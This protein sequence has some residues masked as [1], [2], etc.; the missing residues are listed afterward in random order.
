MC[1]TVKRV[2][3]R[4]EALNFIV[5]EINPFVPVRH[6]KRVHTS[7]VPR[8]AWQRVERASALIAIRPR[9]SFG[10]ST[11]APAKGELRQAMPCEENAAGC[12]SAHSCLVRFVWRKHTR[13]GQCGARG[14]RC[15][16]TSVVCL[17]ED[18]LIKASPACSR[19]HRGVGC[20][21]RSSAASP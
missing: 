11:G 17:Y 2:S 4:R 8:K 19:A 7:A 21:H 10:W 15:S 20:A 12:G 1:L 13:Q 9:A 14:P 6:P 18:Q 5:G 3:A 16:A